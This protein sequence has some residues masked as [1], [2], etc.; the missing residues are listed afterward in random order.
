MNF[1]EF[2]KKNLTLV[3][4]SIFLNLALAIAL[5]FT[6]KIAVIKP[7]QQPADTKIIQDMAA[8]NKKNVAVLE[9]KLL[10]VQKQH[11]Q[12]IIEYQEETKKILGNY[13]RRIVNLEAKRVNNVKKITQQYQND[14]PGLAQEFS[15]ATGIQ[16][17]K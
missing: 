5:Y 4:F 15:N 3:N 13:E 16:V 10:D 1:I 2:F 14:L 11:Q 8:E 9:Q 7:T 17:S 12:N 6:Y